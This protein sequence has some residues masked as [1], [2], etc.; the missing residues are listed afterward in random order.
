[1]FHVALYVTVCPARILTPSACLEEDRLKTL[2][3]YDE[4]NASARLL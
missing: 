1:M 2:N 3:L 4:V